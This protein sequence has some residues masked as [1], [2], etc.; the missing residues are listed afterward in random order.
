MDVIVVIRGG[1]MDIYMTKCMAGGYQLDSCATG[2]GRLR[3]RPKL[4]KQTPTTASRRRLQII[5]WRSF[6]STHVYILSSSERIVQVAATA[7]FVVET[8]LSGG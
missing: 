1:A 6:R 5:L 4:H 3:R 2:T 8:R 7:N